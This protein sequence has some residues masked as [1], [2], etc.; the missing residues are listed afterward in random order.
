GLSRRADQQ[1][2][3]WEEAFVPM[4][5]ADSLDEAR[6]ADGRPLVASE[7]VLLPHRI[8]PEPPER[9]R[10]WW[11][12]LVAGLVLGTAVLAAARFAPRTLGVVAGVFWLA[13]GLLGALLL[14]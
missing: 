2:S 8:A 9:P 13:C 5:L 14:F 1:L 10:P 12:W 3:R 11:P 7:Q 6:L 4:R